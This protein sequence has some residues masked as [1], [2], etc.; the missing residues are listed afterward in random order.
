M[1]HFLIDSHYLL[2][3]FLEF[4]KY[5][6][7]SLA[8]FN[9]CFLLVLKNENRKLEIEMYSAFLL[10]NYICGHFKT[11]LVIMVIKAVGIP[12]QVPT[13]VWSTIGMEEAGILAFSFR[14]QESA[15]IVADL[16]VKFF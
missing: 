5:I 3:Y 2:V 11:I 16:S 1:I 8:K 12:Q 4:S 14:F 7:I 9:I 6:S 13:E 15:P 10:L